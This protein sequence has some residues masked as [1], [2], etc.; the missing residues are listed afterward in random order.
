MNLLRA[1][2][3][4]CAANAQTCCREPALH[5]ATLLRHPAAVVIPPETVKHDRTINSYYSIF[6]YFVVFPFF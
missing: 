3:E 6:G 4:D 2:I 1:I 5:P